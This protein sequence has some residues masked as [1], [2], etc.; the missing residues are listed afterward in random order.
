V[1]TSLTVLLTGAVLAAAAAFWVLRAY[2]RAGGGAS[3]ARPALAA[4][5]LVTLVGLGIYLVIGKPELAGGAY[6]QRLEALSD[7]DPTTFTADE[8]LAV[9]GEAAREN[10][11]DPLPHLYRGQVL[12]RVGRAEEAARAFDAALRRDPQ[13]AEAMLGMGRALVAVEG[14]A[15]SPDA[16]RMFEQASALTNDPGPWIYQAVAA[17]EQGRDDDARRLWGEALTRMSEDDPRREM[18]RRMSTGG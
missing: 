18:A 3:S 12:L 15:V 11:N 7:R 1:W 2:R 13:L 9:L 8:A 5:L 16:Q 10:P 6:A 17:M 4:C 14:G